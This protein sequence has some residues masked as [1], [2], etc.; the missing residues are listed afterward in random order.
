MKTPPTT[1]QALSMLVK[2]HQV[3]VLA[4]IADRNFNHMQEI[5]VFC[6]KR[7]MQGGEL[8]SDAN[9]SFSLSNVR[10]FVFIVERDHGKGLC[11]EHTVTV[12]P[13]RSVYGFTVTAEGGGN[14]DIPGKARYHTSLVSHFTHKLRAPVS[15][16]WQAPDLDIP[17]WHT[18]RPDPLDGVW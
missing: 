8:N 16:N 13:S 1:F 7:I 9:F 3:K 5:Q 6:I 18:D 12:V 11:S 17:S 15:F 14:R 10:K 4:G 2:A